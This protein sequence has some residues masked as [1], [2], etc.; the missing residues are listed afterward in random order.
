MTKRSIIHVSQTKIRENVKAVREGRLSDI[1]PRIMVKTEG[2]RLQYGHS[3][4]V[5]GPCMVISRPMDPE[6]CGSSGRHVR[7]WIETEAEV[8]LLDADDPTAT[9]EAFPLDLT[10]SPDLDDSVPIDV[11]LPPDS[12]P[13]L[14]VVEPSYR[15]LAH[16][17]MPQFD[18]PTCSKSNP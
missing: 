6:Q 10:G 5:K 17:T 3:V 8:V 2:I 7:V 12:R 9:C 16:S 13:Y 14:E 11:V 1:Q 15:R 18:C 4:E